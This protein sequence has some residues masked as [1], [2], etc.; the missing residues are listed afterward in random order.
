MIDMKLLA[1]VTPTY[2]YHG[3]S[4]RKTFWEG[5]FT[6]EGKFTLGEFSSV[7]IKIYGRINVRK[8]REING[9]DKYATL[10]MPLKFGSMGNMI[11][12][13]S[14]PKDNFVISGKG[15]INSLGIK[16]KTRPKK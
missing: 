11:I 16:S 7:N 1:V 3:F 6:G 12:T 5:N 15:L 14:E 9:S 4:T 13:S 8:H 2:I 10:Y